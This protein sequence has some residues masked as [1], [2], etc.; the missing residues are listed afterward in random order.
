[1]AF[2]HVSLNE[3]TTIR[4]EL[5]PPKPLTLPRKTATRRR[6]LHRGAKRFWHDVQCDGRR[7]H[8]V[9]LFAVTSTELDTD[10]LRGAV[11]YLHQQ[12]RQVCPG[13]R[14]F[15]WPEFQRRGALHYHGILL[16]PPWTDYPPARKW[17]SKHWP[18]AQIQT[19]IKFKSAAWFR[20]NE[21]DYVLKEV[22]KGHRKG[23]EQWYEEMPNGWRTFSNHRL[24]FTPEEH[25]QHESRGYTRILED[26]TQQLV[27]VDEHVSAIGGC[28]LVADRVLRRR[29]RTLR[30]P[31]R[32]SAPKGRAAAADNR[33]DGN[34]DVGPH[35]GARGAPP[36]ASS[37][38][39]CAAGGALAHQTHPT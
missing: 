17:L 20:D 16:D 26:G 35:C 2:R 32:R 12:L 28:R 11:E 37:R 24:T 21:A 9:L 38:S 14:Y 22:G 34:S 19:W 39:A 4:N 7:F 8:R 31:R 27:A 1:M 23:Y 29:R 10:P 25:A 36:G 15:W 6:R 13:L 3:C 30:P 33:I 18:H 5:E